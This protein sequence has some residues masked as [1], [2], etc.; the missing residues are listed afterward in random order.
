MT[1]K[2]MSPQRACDLVEFWIAAP[3]PLTRPQVQERAAELGWVVHDGALMNP[4]DGLS[5]PAVLTGVLPD[6]TFGSLGFRVTDVVRDRSPQGAD[7][8]NDQFTLLVREGTARWGKPR[9]SRGR[10]QVATWEL[11]DG[12]RVGAR[13][14][15]TSVV[16]EYTT[17]QQAA[18]LRRRGE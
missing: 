7:F 15:N 6:G 14:T 11:P 9:L 18:A 2:S 13:G 12:A 5:Q 17:P 8:L 4:V 3:W 1:W 10:A 16:A